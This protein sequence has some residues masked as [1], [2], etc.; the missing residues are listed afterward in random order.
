MSTARPSTPPSISR[1]HFLLE[2]T[3]AASALSLAGKVATPTAHAAV[4]P[5]R[6]TWPI[7]VFSKPFQHLNA[8]ATAEFVESIG[9]D[10]IECPVRPKGQIEPEKAADL[11]PAYVQA[12]KQRGREMYLATTDITRIDQKFAESTLRALSKSGVRRIRLGYYKYDLSRSP[13][14]Q[15]G[16]A[17]AALRD[18]A[19]ACGEL[20]IQAGYQ[21]HSGRNYMGA[22]VWDIYSAIKDL[23][24]RHMGF[25]FD[26]GHATV[27]GGTDWPI[28]AKLVESHLTTVY[29][30]DFFWKKSEK[31]WQAAWCPLGDGMVNRSYFESLR[32]TSYRGPVSQHHEYHWTSESEMTAMMRR[33][34]RVLKEWLAA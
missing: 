4:T 5:A 25:C 16:E 29:I 2:T 1:R 19:A 13:A 10:G 28:Q 11:L 32:K 34:L 8:E 23:D 12:L 24:P 9:W 6:T 26:I 14:D 7:S 20:G 17:A 33:D 27:E 22:P 18:I 3:L 15:I 21:N 30:K 31:G